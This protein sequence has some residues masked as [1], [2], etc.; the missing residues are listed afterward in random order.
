MRHA[1]SIPQLQ[2]RRR[3]TIV[4]QTLL[5]FALIIMNGCASNL[6][7]EKPHK[8]T[9]EAGS[10]VRWNGCS[11][12]SNDRVEYQACLI[13]M[14][15]TWELREAA[16]VKMILIDEERVN[17]AWVTR[18]YNACRADFCNPVVIDVED[19]TL[20]GAFRLRLGWFVSGAGAAVAAGAAIASKYAIFAGVVL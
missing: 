11:D 20:M 13:A 10:A 1:S 15:K 8:E 4:A 18:T 12:Y 14:R 6:G 2:I 19:P 16:P 3:G 9:I 7:V 5:V 17:S